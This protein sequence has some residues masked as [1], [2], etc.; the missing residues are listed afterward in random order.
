M[1]VNSLI[2][3]V[4]LLFS[5]ALVAKDLVY[6]T[7]GEWPPYLSNNL[8]ENGYASHI[9]KEAFSAVG[10]DVTFGFFPWERSFQYAKR[11]INPN[12]EIW[13]GSLVWVHTRDREKNFYYS[14]SVVTD[15]EVLFFLND[16][17]FSWDKP[18]ALEGKI[19][20]GTSH[21][22]YPLFEQAEN[23]GLVRIDRAGNYDILFKRLLMN[24]IDAVPQVKHV[25]NYYL[26]N[27]LTAKERAKITFSESVI[28]TRSYHLILSKKLKKNKQLIELFNEGLNKIKLNG[29]YKELETSFYSGDYDNIKKL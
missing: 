22:V 14:D 4:L 20:G 24:R 25:G 19:I 8:P 9:V 26:Q 5:N 28:E 29:K 11:G 6:L 16:S 23:E 3:S 27:N 12:G 21:T 10:I 15:Q 13:H 18:K 17:A 1:V 7:S 2:F